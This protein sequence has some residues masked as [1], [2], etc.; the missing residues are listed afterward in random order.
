MRI[1]VAGPNLTDQSHGQFVVHRAGCAD[2]ARRARRDPAYADAWLICAPT[3][4]ATV[5]A[6]YGD[7]IAES[8]GDWR[9]YL[10]EVHF[11]PCC[12]SLPTE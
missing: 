3:R 9:A 1:A 8:D 11:A 5:Q 10:C 7:Q 4:R 2:V 6:I 12:A